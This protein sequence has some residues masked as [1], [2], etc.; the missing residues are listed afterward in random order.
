MTAFRRREIACTILRDTLGRFHTEIFLV[1]II[2]LRRM[3]APEGS[4]LIITLD[5]V[6]GLEPKFTSDGR[7]ALATFANGAAA[8]R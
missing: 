7:Y 6:A 4:A 3:A 1:R 5:Q 2:P 8:F